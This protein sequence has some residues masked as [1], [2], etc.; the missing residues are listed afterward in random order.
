MLLISSLTLKAQRE[1]IRGVVLTAMGKPIPGATIML[2]RNDST[3]VYAYA[4]S[5]PDGSFQ[6]KAFPDYDSLVIEVR[7]IS[8]E[9]I[10]Q[11]I[12]KANVEDLR[13][14]MAER[15]GELREVVIKR[16]LPVVAK[17]DT[18]IFNAGSYKT[19]EVRKVEDL[20]KSMQGFSVD[21]NGRLS[22][23][24]KPVERVMIEGDDLAEQG[25]QLVTRNLDA[26]LI[27]KV[28]VIDNYNTNRLMRGVERTN[29]VG[30]NLRISS[31][32]KAKLSGS[33]E[34]GLSPN[35]RYL[36][37]VNNI[38]IGKQVKWLGF[39]NYNNVARDPAGNVRYYYQQE[40]GQLDAEDDDG[41]S[42]P[43]LETGS[44][45]IPKVGDRYV[46]DNSDL[47]LALMNSWKIGK[48]TRVNAMGGYND[49]SLRNQAASVV[50]TR[51]SDLEKW[52]LNN[53]MASGNRSRDLLFRVSLQTDEGKRHARR[54][55]LAY[56]HA[57]ERNQFSDLLS[58]DA[59]DSLSEQLLNQGAIVRFG[60]QETFLLKK[61]VF[62]VHMEIVTSSRAQSLDNHSLRYV[63]FWGLDSS[64]LGNRHRLDQDRLKLSLQLKVNGAFGRLQYEYGLS[65]F[66]R[67]AS[68]ASQASTYSMAFK[69]DS[70]RPYVKLGVHSDEYLAGFKGGI[71]SGKKGLFGIQVDAG[72]A[73]LFDGYRSSPFASFSGKASY[74]HRFSLFRSLRLQYAMF[75]GFEEF[76][77]VFPPQ[78][79]S[80]NGNV[81]N[82]LAFDGPTHWQSWTGYL[83][84]G[85]IYKQRN[86]SLNASY[87]LLPE[88]YVISMEARPG[89]TEL[90][91]LRGTDNR[92][93]NGILHWEQYFKWLRGRLGASSGYFS[94]QSRSQLNGQQGLSSRSS[95]TA[96]GWW[97]SGFDFPV[98]AELKAGLAYSTGSW[99][100]GAVNSNWQYQW[101]A[102]LKVKI[103]S[104]IY[105]AMTSKV[106]YLTNG[107]RLLGLD[108]YATRQVTKGMRIDL[109]GINLLNAGRVVERTVMPFYVS[110]SVFYL[111]GRYIMLSASISF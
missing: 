17:S 60:W 4:I 11:K 25:Y 62:R 76:D 85:N 73:S 32:Y 50:A 58:G 54:V 14:G 44:F 20:L 23:N 55:N 3:Q 43:L 18:I 7:H 84:S 35:N 12:D 48:Y 42:K 69:P 6:F 88:S 102:K 38:F 63:S 72:Y 27:D 65:A 36:A 51:I 21:A 82:G 68:Y 30:I 92:L 37:D 33:A 93:F 75:K 61:S 97:T 111:V 39:A 81:L 15:A 47:G 66:R 8:Y 53:V 78:L 67:A 22:F 91:F 16:E 26:A 46:R 70:V 100:G 52:T 40:G 56:Q 28:E 99:N 74:T 95:L 83:Q 13:I 10:R 49:L 24:G 110:E 106:F 79:I 96:E 29:K 71:R 89:F 64:Y 94:S 1:S 77:N 104:K 105:A 103:E 31:Q 45:T 107:S 41:M 98:N 5:H 34:L 101:S 108:I 109:T 86:W 19:A 2:K 59:R 90:G 80:G 9:T 57:R 87:K